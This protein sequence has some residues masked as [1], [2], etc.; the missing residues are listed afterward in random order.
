[1]Q[2]VITMEQAL[3]RCGEK[4]D[5]KGYEAA[6]SAIEMVEMLVEMKSRIYSGKTIPNVA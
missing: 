5:N 3:A 1:M 4:L 6:L 2:K